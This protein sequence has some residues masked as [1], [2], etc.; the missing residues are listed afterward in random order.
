[1]A[2]NKPNKRVTSAGEIHRMVTV[3][4]AYSKAEALHSN[5][6]PTVWCG[7]SVV[8][9]R[10]TP[11]AAPSLAFHPPYAAPKTVSA[12]PAQ[13]SRTPASLSQPKGSLRIRT[14]RSSVKADEE[15][16]STV[17][18]RGERHLAQRV[19]R[20]GGGGAGAGGVGVRYVSVD[21]VSVQRPPVGGRERLPIFSEVVGQPA[22]DSSHTHA[23]AACQ[24]TQ[25]EQRNETSV[26]H[27]R[28]K[29]RP[30][31]MELSKDGLNEHGGSGPDDRDENYK[32]HTHR[33]CGGSQHSLQLFAR[34]ADNN[35]H[36]IFR[37]AQLAG[38]RVGVVVG[39]GKEH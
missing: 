6:P 21:G 20:G 9:S 12:L 25:R 14:D 22:P 35:S 34:D 13:Q 30:L 36:A 38:G 3:Y 18:E 16:D 17:D 32:C 28:E 10:R 15:A 5:T 8:A 19:G 29:K 1:M 2:P 11:A 24:S 27:I 37:V 26:C 23:R 39:G 31:K 4:T 33:P 7:A